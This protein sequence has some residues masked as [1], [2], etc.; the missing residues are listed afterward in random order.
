[1][2]MILI[3]SREKKYEHI[4]RYFDLHG[5]EYRVEKLD[6]GDYMDSE[7]L[8]L[9][10]DRKRNLN[11]CAQ[12]LYSPDS[13]R[14]WRELRRAHENHVKLVF[15]VEHGAGIRSIEDVK[16]WT[17]PYSYKITGRKVSNEMFK[18]HLA[19]GVDWKFCRKSETGKKIL[20]ILGGAEND[21]I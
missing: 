8:T 14:F 5:I 13:G 1:M 2:T 17:S 6:V 11:E 4:A 7:N 16:T 20:E 12:N 15:L 10:I 3:D 21:R 18:T 9:I 19:Y